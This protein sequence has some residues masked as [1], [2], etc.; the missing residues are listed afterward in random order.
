[1]RRLLKYVAVAIAAS[2]SLAALLIWD[3]FTSKVIV[4]NL[5]SRDLTEVEV[6]IGSEREANLQEVFWRGN[7]KRGQIQYIGKVARHE[8]LIVVRLKRAG[9]PVVMYCCYVSGAGLSER[10]RVCVRDA[11][12]LEAKTIPPLLWRYWLPD[13]LDTDESPVRC[14][15]PQAP[16]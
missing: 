15:K 6:G 14:D 12:E 9:E 3:D 5:T 16:S 11:G 1:M 8:G 7:I 2:F 4:E 10:V 13:G